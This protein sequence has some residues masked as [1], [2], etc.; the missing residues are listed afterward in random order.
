MTDLLRIDNDGPRIL[1]C[2]F[3]GSEVEWA[4]KLYVS[5]NAGAFRLLVPASLESAI[6]EMA[7][8]EG[9]AVSRGPWPAMR[10]PEGFEILFDDGTPDPL[11]LHLMPASFDRLPAPGDVAGEWLFSV[12]TRPRGGDRPRL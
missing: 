10:L 4:G 7:P 2:S 12:W 1:A 5:L 6:A 9:V 3:W 8:A 11:A